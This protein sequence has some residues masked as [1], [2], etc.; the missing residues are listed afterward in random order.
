M[1]IVY[2]TLTPADLFMEQY[3]VAGQLDC[4]FSPERTFLQSAHRPAPIASKDPVILY[5]AW[6]LLCTGSNTCSTYPWETSTHRP[7]ARTKN[8]TTSSEELPV[9]TNKQQTIVFKVILNELWAQSHRQLFLYA[10]GWPLWGQQ[11]G[12]G[13]LSNINFNLKVKDLTE[14]PVCEIRSANF[15]STLV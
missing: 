10:L 2:I 6:L 5:G 11:R 3:N 1:P 8:D 4:H 7:V 14:M 15:A 13:S 12:S 9:L